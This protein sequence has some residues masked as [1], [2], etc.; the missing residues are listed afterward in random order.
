MEFLL[1][2]KMTATVIKDNQIVSQTDAGGV[3]NTANCWK[4]IPT[5][6]IKQDKIYTEYYSAEAVPVR[7]IN[8]DMN[9]YLANSDTVTDSYQERIETRF[10]F[11]DL[12]ISTRI[13]APTSVILSNPIDVT[14]ADHITIECEIENEEAGAAEFY[15][16]DRTDEIPILSNQSRHIIKERLFL[17]EDTRFPVNTT[18]DIT[19]YEDDWESKKA[20]S[21]LTAKDFKKHIYTLTYTTDRDYSEYKP[22]GDAITVKIIIR[23]YAVDKLFKIKNFIIHKHGDTPVW[24]LQQ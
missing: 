2:N 23:Q 10:G 8:T 13:A 21:S 22:V 9:P 12:K 20:Y 3:Q 17:E 11:K 24:N 18:K 4:F 6:N 1:T 15:I 19:L 7:N 16:I 5:E 14:Y